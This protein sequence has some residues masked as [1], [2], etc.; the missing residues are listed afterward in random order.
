MKLTACPEKIRSLRNQMAEDLPSHINRLIARLIDGKWMCQGIS[1]IPITKNKKC[2]YVVLGSLFAGMIY[3]RG[4]QATELRIRSDESVADLL[5]SIKRVLSY[6]SCYEKH[7]D[8]NPADRLIEAMRRTIEDT[9]TSLSA[10]A[11]ESMRERRRR[12]ALDSFTS[13]ADQG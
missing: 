3:V 6:V 5:V 8:C 1:N 7:P 10:A 4:S 13:R 12:T 2:D 11:K 9:D